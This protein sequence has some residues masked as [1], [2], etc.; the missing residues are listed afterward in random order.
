MK[1]R[2]VLIAFDGSDNAFRAVEYIGSQFSGLG[3]IKVTLFYVTPNIPPQ[4]W[5]DGH[6]LAPAEREERQKVID[7]WFSNQ[8]VVLNPLFEKARKI[9]ID[10]GVT[11]TQV[12]TKMR[13]DVTSVAEAVLEEARTGEYRTLVLGR[14][15]MAPILA[16]SLATT[17]L[18]K[19][20]GFAICIV[21]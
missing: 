4:F 7:T 13:T 18:H 15:G 3:D 1:G 20:T 9:L 21:E 17:I 5:D 2:D 11:P 19:G 8:K 12:E 14:Q 10:R 6:I 16:G